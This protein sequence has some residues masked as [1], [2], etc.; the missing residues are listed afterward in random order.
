MYF[1]LQT[2]PA[3]PSRDDSAERYARA[4]RA[5]LEREM[6]ENEDDEFCGCG[7]GCCD[8]GDDWDER[9]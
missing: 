3:Y 1:F 9:F 2:Q 7:C 4:R 6:D 8:E 5:Q